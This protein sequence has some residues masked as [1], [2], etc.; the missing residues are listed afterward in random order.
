MGP[1]KSS[2]KHFYLPP[3]LQTQSDLLV[4]WPKGQSSLNDSSDLIQCLFFL[5]FL[6]KMSSLYVT[7]KLG[8][9]TL[10]KWR[11]CCLWDPKRLTRH[12]AL[13][14]VVGATWYSDLQLTL[15]GICQHAPDHWAPRNFTEFSWNLR[16][17]RSA[18][19]NGF[20]W[21]VLLLV[22]PELSHAV[23]VIWQFT[24]G[25]IVSDGL[26]CLAVGVGSQLGLYLHLVSHSQG[27]YPRLLHTVVSGS[28]REQ[29]LKVS[30]GPDS[31]LP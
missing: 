19:W 22:S 5:W 30:L 28:K 29:K 2:T 4:V 27:S 15:E 21:A 17:C 25:R 26:T 24:Q 14:T 8:Q 13:F 9:K 31:E 1:A 7:W 3:R 16:F 11:T 6:I 18:I 12:C 10:T 20:K 23:I